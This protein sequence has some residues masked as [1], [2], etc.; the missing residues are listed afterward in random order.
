[1][2]SCMYRP[3]T[4]LWRWRKSR[5]SVVNGDLNLELGKAGNLP[6]HRTF[7]RMGI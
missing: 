3:L 4:L 6:A 1:M 2:I 5:A 7:K